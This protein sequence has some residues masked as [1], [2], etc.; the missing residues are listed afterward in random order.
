MRWLKRHY[1]CFALH[2]CL[3]EYMPTSSENLSQQSQL[4]LAGVWGV[5]GLL[6]WVGGGGGGAPVL[7]H[8][9]VPH[10]LYGCLICDYGDQ[11]RWTEM[12]K[13]NIQ[14]VFRSFLLNWNSPLKFIEAHTLVNILSLPFWQQMLKICKGVKKNNTHLP[15]ESI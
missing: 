6:W 5:M 4:W 3:T 10:L 14:Y 8:Q 1:Q 2:L 13:Q 11:L 7:D 15:T 9:P 12:R